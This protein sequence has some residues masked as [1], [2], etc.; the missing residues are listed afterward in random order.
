MINDSLRKRLE[1]INARL[2]D[3]EQEL[4]NPEVTKNIKKFQALSIERAELLPIVERARSLDILSK[5]IETTESWISDPELKEDAVIELT[6]LRKKLSEVENELKGLLL[7][8]DP[9]DKKNVLLEIR[10][11]TGGD[12]ST[13]FAADLVR[14]YTKFAERKKWKIEIIS[15]HESGLGGFKEIV[16]KLAGKNAYSTLKFESGGHR[17]SR[18]KKKIVGSRK[19]TQRVTFTKGSK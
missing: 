8:K 15:S 17:V 2:T 3:V 18:I 5:D 1:K 19:R 7:P 12:E 16:I 13:L 10:A 11:G 14:M 9:N 6:G 4:A